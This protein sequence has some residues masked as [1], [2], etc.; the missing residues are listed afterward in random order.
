M[1]HTCTKRNMALQHKR[2]S[3]YLTEKWTSGKQKEAPKNNSLKY[4]ISKHFGISNKT[5]KQQRQTNLSNKLYQ[6]LYIAN[7]VSFSVSPS[8]ACGVIHRSWPPVP[9]LV[10]LSPPDHWFSPP[11]TLC[12]I[13]AAD[14]W[15]WD[16]SRRLEQSLLKEGG[17]A[18][19]LAKITSAW[20][21]DAQP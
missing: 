4:A 18:L 7:K 21:T 13:E 19:W 2:Y 9:P 1:D 12:V 17:P 11:L 20:H 16:S 14:V 6:R 8:G 5:K 15:W 3:P 10:V